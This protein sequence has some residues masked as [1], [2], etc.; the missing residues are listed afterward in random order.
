LIALH[1][2]H[3]EQRACQPCVGRWRA[4]GSRSCRSIPRRVSARPP[5][6]PE[7][8]GSSFPLRVEGRRACPPPLPVGS[9][10]SGP[11]GSGLAARARPN[12]ADRGTGAAIQ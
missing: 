1:A 4:R 8:W 3:E 10:R 9:R 12:S 7:S 11:S 5:R 6:L 2:S